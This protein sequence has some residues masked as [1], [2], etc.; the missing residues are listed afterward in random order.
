MIHQP[1]KQS[2]LQ[3]LR[4]VMLCDDVQID[5]RIMQQ[6]QALIERGCEVMVLG[7]ITDGYEASEQIGNVKID[8][9]DCTKIVSIRRAREA[10]INEMHA[11]PEAKDTPEI[12][13]VAE[14]EAQLLKTYFGPDYGPPRLEAFILQ[15]PRMLRGILK[16]L[17]WPPMRLEVIRRVAPRLP[18]VLQWALYA[19]TLLLTPRPKAFR[20]HMRRLRRH[21]VAWFPAWWGEG[22][23]AAR[24]AA[25]IVRLEDLESRIA[26]FEDLNVWELAIYDRACFMRP[27]II[28]VHDLPQ[29][30]GAY[31]AGQHL[32]VPV[33]YDAHEL[34]PFIHT[35][36]PHE[37]EL[38]RVIEN[39]FIRRV[40]KSVIVNPLAAKVQ[41]VDYSIATPEALLNSVPLPD[42]LKRGVK[43][44]HLRDALKL[45]SEVKILLFQG[46]ASFDRN[47]GTLIQGLA[48]T[49]SHIH[50]V[51][52]G[53]GADLAALQKLADDLGIGARVHFPPPV[54]QAEL[55]FW[56]AS[57]DAGIIPY[58]AIDKNT[59]TCS[60]NKLFEFIAVGLPIIANNLPYL[61]A[62]VAGE[63]FGVTRALKNA[64]DYAEAI[65]TMFMPS[66]GG[67]ETRFHENLL[68]RADKY[69][70]PA[71]EK[72]LLKIYHE[73]LPDWHNA[74]QPLPL[75]ETLSPVT[76][77]H[78]KKAEAISR[79][80]R[81]F[82]GPYNTAGIPWVMAKAERNLGLDSKAICFPSGVA[83]FESDEALDP[84]VSPAQMLA[85]FRQ[86]A[87][88]YDVF[89]FHFGYSLANDSLADVPLLKAMGKKV[90]FYFH[91]CDIRQSK[92]TIRKYEFSACKECWPQR[93]S[94]NRDIAREMA[95]R[96][97]DAIW[98]STPDLLEFVPGSSLFLQ[99]LDLQ[100]FP[101]RAAAK[102]HAT[103]RVIHAP[104]D[105][106]LKGTHYI[107]AS[108]KQ[109]QSEGMNLE[110]ILLEGLAHDA[111]QQELAQADL[112]IDQ[113]LFG[114]YGKFAVELMATGIPTLCHVRDD[115]W[116]HYPQQP[117]IIRATPHSLTDILRE[118][119]GAPDRWRA[120]VENGRMFVEQYHAAHVAAS[121]AAQTYQRIVG[122]ALP[123]VA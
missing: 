67:D 54:P 93:C 70:W 14:A 79:P 92:E 94:P 75:A 44:R 77:L 7:R 103:V 69:L 58:Q 90:I 89:V 114:S 59:V 13:D 42:G 116:A 63:K 113:M 5:R 85:R 34:Y 106:Q 45:P 111:L 43:T 104:S 24:K 78:D 87:E 40:Q 123:K 50:L 8:R 82:H 27:D 73:V 117:P 46:W 71:Q 96:Y 115:V 23:K 48:R 102:H 47:I 57:A 84:W 32:G 29:L 38:L 100:M 18:V 25:E 55:L 120:Q 16:M 72:I 10:T 105:R 60:P 37:Q 2:A 4:V 6:S 98:V 61:E 39:Y 112:A 86:Y 83:K 68:H 108:V 80:L 21:L 36:Q 95:T 121:K 33:I 26:R 12:I 28:H 62:V 41:A 51:I 11:T 109:L 91:G 65:R 119:V 97:A 20:W 76:P 101:M 9:I 30:R 74:P 1:Q 81:V 35:L 56:V 52:M 15:Q 31:W 17:V 110:L 64:E 88:Y 3:G 53:Y 122:D 22:S 107:E 99:P 66:S 49:P 19:P 118:W